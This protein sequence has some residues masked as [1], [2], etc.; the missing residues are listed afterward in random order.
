MLQQ[1]LESGVLLVTVLTAVLGASHVVA[2]DV[3]PQCTFVLG[4]VCLETDG[5]LPGLDT[6]NHQA[7][8]HIFSTREVDKLS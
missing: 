7:L 4:L 5:T 6:I 3:I 1:S 8:H 2:L